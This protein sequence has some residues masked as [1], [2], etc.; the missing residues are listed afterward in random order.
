MMKGMCLTMLERY[1]DILTPKEVKEILH[2]SQPVIYGLL[3]EK[4]IKAYRSGYRW[5]IPKSSLLDYIRTMF[6]KG[7][8]S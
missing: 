4:D 2:K 5:M 1:G 6:L 7:N 3:K 8:S